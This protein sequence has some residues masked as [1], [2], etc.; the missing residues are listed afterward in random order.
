MDEVSLVFN[1]VLDLLAIKDNSIFQHYEQL[2]MLKV[3]HTRLV[4]ERDELSSLNDDFRLQLSQLRQTVSTLQSSLDDAVQELA[5]WRS[6]QTLIAHVSQSSTT[7]VSVGVVQLTPPTKRQSSGGP[8][9]EE[10]LQGFDVLCRQFVY[11]TGTFAKIGQRATRLVADVER[12]SR[13]ALVDCSAQLYDC[14]EWTSRALGVH[15]KETLALRE[16]LEISE[17]RRYQQRQAVATEFTSQMGSLNEHFDELLEQKETIESELYQLK[18]W[19]ANAPLQARSVGRSTAEWATEYLLLRETTMLMWSDLRQELLDSFRLAQRNEAVFTAESK[20]VAVVNEQLRGQL[21][22]L[23]Q[24]SSAAERAF[25]Q[26]LGAAEAAKDDV[27]GTVALHRSRLAKAVEQS[28]IDEAKYIAVQQDLR[29]KLEVARLQNAETSQFLME[30]RTN[31]KRN[32]ALLDHKEKELHTTRQVLAALQKRCAEMRSVVGDLEES[33]A[34]VT[35]SLR[36]EITRAASEHELHRRESS[37]KE[38]E[39]TAR[40]ENL[41]REHAQ[42]RK[43]FHRVLDSLRKEIQTKDAA[44]LQHATLVRDMQSAHTSRIR[45]LENENVLLRQQLGKAVLRASAVEHHSTMETGLLHKVIAKQE[46][47]KRD[48]LSVSDASSAAAIQDLQRQVR[49]LHRACELGAQESAMLR[50]RAAAS[51]SVRFTPL[52]EPFVN[53]SAQTTLDSS[54][55]T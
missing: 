9:L 34:T 7:L 29:Q 22:T 41:S 19:F 2:Q 17:E 40:Y 48:A 31:E 38:E 33:K 1:R 45:E 46:Q 26:R 3:E 14:L 35:A 42:D 32:E 44:A 25:K 12:V 43:E 21:S 47:E 4:D 28:K 8:A 15:H 24:Q 30:A 52:I 13:S 27:Q 37:I 20:A 23:A 50:E 54:T 6:L 18:R 16:S 36:E 51:A 5:V 11:V 39:I 55:R 10:Q 53:I 49:Q